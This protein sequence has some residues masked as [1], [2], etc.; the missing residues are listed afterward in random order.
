MPGRAHTRINQRKYCCF[1]GSHSGEE[2]KFAQD[3]S[4]KN[5][6]GHHLLPLEAKVK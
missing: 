1:E 3:E 5:N 4:I 2:K 6:Q